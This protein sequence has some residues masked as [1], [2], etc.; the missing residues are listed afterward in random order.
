MCGEKCACGG[1]C[2]ESDECKKIQTTEVKKMPLY[3]YPKR[4][5]I[6][7]ICDPEKDMEETPNR[8]CPVHK[9]PKP[10]KK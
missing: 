4:N 6:M 1:S 10:P 5:D 7:C 3:P 8:N 9:P 2:D